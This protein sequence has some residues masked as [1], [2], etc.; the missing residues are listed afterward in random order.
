MHGS[1]HTTDDCH[2]VF[3]GISVTN[4]EWLT[5]LVFIL[6]HQDI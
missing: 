1:W 5:F 3:V 4:A 6:V 2:D